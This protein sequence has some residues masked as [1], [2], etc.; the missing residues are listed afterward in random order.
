M[1]RKNLMIK[2]LLKYF[3]NGVLLVIPITITIYIIV[4]LFNFLDRLIPF[5]FFKGSGLLLLLGI[6]TLVGFLGSTFIANPV[7]RS[8]NEL[9]DR[10]PL[11]KTLYSSIK[12]LLSA[13][14]GTKKRFNKPVLVKVNESSNLEKLGFITDEDLSSL[15]IDDNEKVAVYLPH[16]YN[17][18]GN[19]FVVSK[20]CVTPIDKNAAEVMKYIVSGGVS[21]LNKE[22]E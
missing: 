11:V 18:S 3:L 15:G 22:D 21:E 9:L 2:R 1:N 6:I 13:F 4:W 16:S 5:N 20:S 14:V 8:I 19:L 10:V 12:D 17:F 7:K